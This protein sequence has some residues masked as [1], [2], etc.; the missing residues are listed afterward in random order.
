M[1]LDKL[2]RMITSDFVVRWKDAAVVVIAP[3]AIEALSLQPCRSCQIDTILL[4]R[5]NW[6]KCSARQWWSADSV[7][8]ST[9]VPKPPCL[10][11]HVNIT[12]ARQAS[13]LAA[14]VW[15]W[16]S[17]KPQRAGSVRIPGSSGLRG[18]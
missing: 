3:L 17:L 8:S 2:L 10:F 14:C 15:W 18:P 4:P 7:P 13:Q 6:P 5:R 1:D 11:D 12:L 16:W 9:Q